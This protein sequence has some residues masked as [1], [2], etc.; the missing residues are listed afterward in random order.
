MFGVFWLLVASELD[1]VE[2]PKSLEKSPWLCLA[3][4]SGTISN[5]SSKLLSASLGSSGKRD[6]NASMNSSLSSLY[7]VLLPLVEFSLPKSVT[8]APLGEYF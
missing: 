2:F 3:S 8:N 5:S 4:S 7:R 6:W 1:V